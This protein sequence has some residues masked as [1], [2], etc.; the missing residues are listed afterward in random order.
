MKQGSKR[1]RFGSN[2]NRLIPK[3]SNI[4]IESFVLN[5][6]DFGNRSYKPISFRQ[7]FRKIVYVLAL[8]REPSGVFLLDDQINR[9]ENSVSLV[10]HSNKHKVLFMLY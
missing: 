2:T 8:S 7:L 5:R 10:Y 1:P 9:L 3:H 6:S 4:G